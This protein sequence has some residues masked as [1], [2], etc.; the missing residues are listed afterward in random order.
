MKKQID[1]SLNIET[2]EYKQDD[3]QFVIIHRKPPD[4]DLQNI[5]EELYSIFKKYV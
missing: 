2:E 1:K 4:T 5:K 3:V